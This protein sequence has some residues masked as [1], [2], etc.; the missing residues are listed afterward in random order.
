MIPNTVS[1]G[2]W[3]LARSGPNARLSNSV[4]ICSPNALDYDSTQGATTKLFSPSAGTGEASI[5]PASYHRPLEL[6][7]RPGNLE[8]QAAPRRRAID[9][10]LIQKQIDPDRL[11]VLDR[12]EKVC[13]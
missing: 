8:E 12:A 3:P 7:E 4:R 1:V 11:K 13:K 10:L 9:A 5:H 2:R 6:G